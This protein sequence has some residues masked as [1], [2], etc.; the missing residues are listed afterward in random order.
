MKGI[1]SSNNSLGWGVCVR[2]VFN[3]RGC[4]RN[5][6]AY[7]GDLRQEAE[8]L[9]GCLRWQLQLCAKEGSVR[10]WAHSKYM[11]VW[12][13]EGCLGPST[14]DCTETAG[15]GHL[16][17]HRFIFPTESLWG[18]CLFQRG[19]TPQQPSVIFGVEVSPH[20]LSVA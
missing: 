20:L 1:K 4:A 13:G 5:V 9:C 14:W 16:T 3:S 12:W 11:C 17:L 19:R 10:S 18:T 7:C 2:D 6:P 15:K 8:A